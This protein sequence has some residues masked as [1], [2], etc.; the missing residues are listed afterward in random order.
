MEN[1]LNKLE[2]SWA[3]VTFQFQKHKDTEVYTVKIAEEDFEVGTVAAA[4][5]TCIHAYLS[6]GGA[7]VCDAGFATCLTARAIPVLHA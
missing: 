6:S 5:M 7:E 2:D 4:A 1:G 3:K